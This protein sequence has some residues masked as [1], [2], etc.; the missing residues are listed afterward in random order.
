[1][2]SCAHPAVAMA[3]ALAFAAVP[4]RAGE[5]WSMATSWGGGPLLEQAAKPVAALIEE[6]TRGEVMVQV[7]AG[8]GLGGALK[9]TETVRTAVAEAGHSWDGYDWTVDKASM[10]F[11]GYA[12]GMNAEQT[13]HWLYQGGGRQ[14]YREYRLQRFGVETLPCGALPAEMGMHSRKRVQSLADLQGLKLRTAGVWAEIAPGLGISTVPLPGV[15][16]H[17]ALERGVID[18]FEWAQLSLNR[19]VGFHTLAKFLIVPGLQQPSTVHACSF[20]KERWALLSEA[21]RR[22]IEIA[23][24]AVTFDLYL[25]VGHAD[26]EAYRFF[27]DAGNEIVVL[28][29]DVVDKARELAFAWAD[30]IA[31]EA[32]SDSW[33]ARVLEHQRAYQ[34]AWA[35][36]RKWRVSAVDPE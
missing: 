9:V 15:E 6:L 8:G 36:S 1:M 27:L 12:G 5:Q 4:A 20:N 2:G 29:R 14:L 26:L 35:G 13:L 3:A 28:D 32:G 19:S 33:F 16:L 18:A 23:A 34:R 24:E 22:A 11:G 7:H 31:A 17:Q 25:S 10:L 30:R 21:N